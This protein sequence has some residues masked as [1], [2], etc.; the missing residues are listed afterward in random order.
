MYNTV[1]IAVHDSVD[2]TY[3]RIYF[4]ASE[5]S[6]EILF[7]LKK[8]LPFGYINTSNRKLFYIY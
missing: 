2:I 4:S 6:Y 5:P 1:Y 3:E 8:Y 7:Q